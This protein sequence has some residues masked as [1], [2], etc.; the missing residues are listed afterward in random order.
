MFW[1]SA[2]PQLENNHA[3]FARSQRDVITRRVTEALRPKY[4]AMYGFDASM[5]Q[6][7]ELAIG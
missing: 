4:G 3:A 7:I 6:N 1:Q 2:S 5:P